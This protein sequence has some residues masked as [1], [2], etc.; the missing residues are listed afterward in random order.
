[1]TKVGLDDFLVAG[2]TA[3]DLAV[4]PRIEWWPS[5]APHALHGLAGRV[6]ETIAPYTEADPVAVLAHLLVGIGNLIGPGPHAVVGRERHPLRPYAALVGQSSRARK[7]TAWATPRYLVGQLDEAWRHARVKTGFSSGEGIIYHV[8]DARVE[9]QP[10]RDRGR[11]VAYET[12]TVDAGEP[13]KRLLVV[14]PELAIVLKRMAR[15]GNSLSGVIRDA[16]DTGDLSTLTKNSPLR[17]TGA[18]LS[19]VAHITEPELHRHLTETECA[20]GFANRF[21]WILV[22]RSK[23]L[24]DGPSVPDADLAP[25][26]G[27]LRDVVRFASSVG[28]LTWDEEATV[29]WRQVYG[30]LTREESGMVGA[31]VGRA[32][33]QVL[34][35]SALYAVLDRSRMIRTPHLLSALAFWEYAEASAR[36]IFGDRL[37]DHVAEVILDAL[38]SRGPLA[39]TGLHATF[40]RHR[41]AAELAAALSR[42]EATGRARRSLKETAG[43][44]AEVWEAID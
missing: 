41:S 35:L 22:R 15:E 42:L 7:G 2:A 24:P 32:E 16:W 43:R 29:A 9:Q 3:R 39:L 1:V 21:L 44:P 36:R 10:V 12:V 23:L 27:A 5:L 30:T 28:E 33:A 37:G 4:L 6:V 8:R 26:V 18:H 20:N 17:A 25:L 13:D 34:R 38:R 19:I 31:I 14:E 40:G 11:V